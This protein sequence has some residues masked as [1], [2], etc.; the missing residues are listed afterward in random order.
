MLNCSALPREPFNQF[1]QYR[2]E[3]YLRGDNAS[4]RTDGGTYLTNATYPSTY[5]HGP[6]Y[7][8]QPYQCGPTHGGMIQHAP[9]QY[10]VDRAPNTKGES[11]D[12]NLPIEP[13]HWF[14]Y[15]PNSRAEVRRSMVFALPSGQDDQDFA[16]F[17][18]PETIASRAWTNKKLVQSPW[19]TRGH[20]RE[21]VESLSPKSRPQELSAVPID[22]NLTTSQYAIDS[23]QAPVMHNSCSPLPPGPDSRYPPHPAFAPPSPIESMSSADRYA[24][25]DLPLL[26]NTYPTPETNMDSPH[27]SLAQMPPSQNHTTGS[28]RRRRQLMPLTGSRKLTCKEP[29]C[30][31]NVTRLGLPCPLHFATSNYS[32]TASGNPLTPADEFLLRARAADYSYAEIKD[33][34]QF[35]EALATLRGRHRKLTKRRDER[36]RKPIWTKKDVSISWDLSR[37]CYPY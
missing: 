34:G 2:H 1:H 3:P 30:N 21:S 12:G 8:D 16:Q 4:R 10:T 22:S 13:C 6:R 29:S 23:T 17:A 32:R 33:K 9:Q 15:G 36:V 14:K 28:P 26:T 37:S 24:F 31:N 25:N 11:S 35:D 20:R 7:I 5:Q 27:S 19:Q 18:K